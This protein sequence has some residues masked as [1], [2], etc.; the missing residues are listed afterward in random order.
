MKPS[1]SKKPGSKK[2][3]FKLNRLLIILVLFGVIVGLLEVFRLQPAFSVGKF[4][5]IW[6]GFRHMHFNSGTVRVHTPRGKRTVEKEYD[7]GPVKIAI[8]L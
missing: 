1:S 7:L 3:G 4:H 5:S 2:S 6:V 8:E